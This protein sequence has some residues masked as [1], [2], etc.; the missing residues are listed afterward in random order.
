MGFTAIPGGDIW[1][2]IGTTQTPTSG[3]AVSFTN[4]PPVKKIRI[5]VDGVIQTASSRQNITFNNDTSAIYSFG[6]TGN[7]SQISGSVL[8]DTKLL[9]G[10]TSSAVA[11][12]ADFI[13][14]YANQACPKLITGSSDSRGANGDGYN[15]IFG[16]YNSTLAINRI[17]LISAT[18]TFSASNTGTFAI[19][20]AF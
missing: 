20:G 4:I 16:S 5:I 17:D 3:S 15:S 8:R 12:F 14:D 9:I 13:I 10:R 1:L 7:V 11:M 6:Y 2:Q 19:Y 18:S